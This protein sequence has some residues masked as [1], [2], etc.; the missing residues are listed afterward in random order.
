MQLHF[1]GRL[2][3]ASIQTDT[4]PDFSITRQSNLDFPR[5]GGLGSQRKEAVAEG[6]GSEVPG[7]HFLPVLLAQTNAEASPCLRRGTWTSLLDLRR[8]TDWGD[9]V[10]RPPTTVLLACFLVVETGA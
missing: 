9:C 4:S 5:T 3:L 2:V 7:H 10:W 8:G 1:A 6:L